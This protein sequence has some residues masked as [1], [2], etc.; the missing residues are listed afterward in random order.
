MS[1]PEEILEAA[2]A[3]PHR[4]PLEDHRATIE[5]LRQKKYTWRE[6]ADFL[7]DR[8]VETDHTTIY[9]LITPLPTKGIKKVLPSEV[10]SDIKIPTVQAYVEAIARCTDTEKNLLKYH[11]N[12]H[13]LTIEFPELAAAVGWKEHAGGVN[14]HYGKL[15]CKLEE[16]LGLENLDS[17]G[18]R[19]YFLPI[20]TFLNYRAKVNGAWMLM[21]HPNLA[22]A[23]RTT[24]V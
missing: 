9:R 13:N 17:K 6:I 19:F 3:A 7:N 21:M 15:S 24:L 11:A 18:Q 2:K 20:G 14:L 8:G 5:T 16:A 23:V 22:E 4:N 1:T 10:F 12:A